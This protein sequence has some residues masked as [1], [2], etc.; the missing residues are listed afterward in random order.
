MKKLHLLLVLLFIGLTSE[1]LIAQSGWSL[2]TNPI[3]TSN[4]LSKV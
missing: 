3:A 2:Q 1:V 4:N